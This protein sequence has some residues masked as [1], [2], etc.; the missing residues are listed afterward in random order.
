MV[1][2]FT[3][4]CYLCNQCLSHLRLL[5]RTPHGEVYSIQPYVIKC[6]SG[7]LR[8][9]RFAP[10]IKLT[11]WHSWNIVYSG[12]KHHEPKPKRNLTLCF[13]FPMFFFL[14]NITF[15]ILDLYHVILTIIHEY[16]SLPLILS[17]PK[18]VIFLWIPPRCV[19]IVSGIDLCLMF[20]SESI[21]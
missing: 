6:V 19:F 16:Y 2:G 11:P 12:V 10:S 21:N 3:T 17:Y 9:I 5:V 20:I 8:V 1:V 7:F 18:L 13:V 15:S 14:V 4:T